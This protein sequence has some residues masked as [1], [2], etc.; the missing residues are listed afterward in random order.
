VWAWINV[1]GLEVTVQRPVD[2]LQ[3]GNDF[4]ERIT[5][6]NRSW[7]SKLWLEVEDPSDLPGHS[8]RRVISLGPRQK[9][10]WR[11]VSRCTRRGRYRVGPLRI[12][13]GDLFGLF[14]RARSYGEAQHVLV[15][16]RA[17]ELQNFLVPPA[18]LPGEGRVRRPAHYITLPFLGM[19]W[20][21]SLVGYAFERGI[22]P[23][24]RHQAYKFSLLDRLFG[25]PW[26]R[27]FFAFAIGEMVLWQSVA[28]SGYDTT[29]ILAIGQALLLALFAILWVEGVLVYGVV[30][31]SLLAVGASMKQAG[32]PF[33]DAVAIFG[34]IGFGLYLLARVFEA[35]STRIKSLTVWLAPLTH[36]SIALTALAVIVNLPLVATHMTATAATLAF[37]GALYVTIAYRGKIYQLGYLGMALLEIAWVIVL[38]INKVAQPQLYAIPGGLYFM[39][40]AYLELQRGQRRYAVAIEILGLGLLLVTSF[41]QSLNG[42]QGLPY[43]ILLLAEA[44]LII[45]WGTIQK[46]KIPFFAGIGA[47]ALNVIAQVIVLISVYDI[48]RWLVAFGVGLLIMAIAIYIERSREQLRIYSRE[49]S[50]TLEKWE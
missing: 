16:P 30:A 27:P 28:F 48:N 14:R 40:I 42:A 33:P 6:L 37:A 19:T 1:R 47:T 15:Y 8:A 2:R 18:A 9:R 4:E 32:T 5:V 35:I 31:F 24:S 21:T 13:S 10:S 29:I 36:S 34:G 23:A 45:W 49:L 50:E 46:R 20:I 3:E 38:F 43:F 41:A 22:K 44:L 39:G 25:H 12:T 17:V 26:A 11:S 7:F